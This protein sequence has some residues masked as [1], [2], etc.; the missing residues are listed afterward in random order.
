MSISRSADAYCRV[1]RA[2]FERPLP[3]PYGAICPD[4]FAG[5]HIVTLT[6]A[7]GSARRAG[8][9][10]FARSSRAQREA[11]GRRVGQGALA[12]AVRD[13]RSQRGDRGS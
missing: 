1:C 11:V 3:Q 12:A 9:A 10:R 6:D 5:G 7:P 2:T 4:C 8:G 13:L